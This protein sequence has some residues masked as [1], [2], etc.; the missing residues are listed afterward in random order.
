MLLILPKYLQ[1]K[2]RYGRFSIVQNIKMASAIKFDN[3]KEL[4][5]SESTNANKDVILSKT[6][7]LKA[8]ILFRNG[9]V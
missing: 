5:S 4:S 7:S 1:R 9:L 6:F 2:T 8:T 3:G